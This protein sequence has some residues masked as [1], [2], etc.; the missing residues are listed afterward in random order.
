MGMIS[1]SKKKKKKGTLHNHALDDLI[2]YIPPLNLAVPET[3][4]L[5][6]PIPDLPDV[7]MKTA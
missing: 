7:K 4:A 5:P 6:L 2:G 1:S 3:L